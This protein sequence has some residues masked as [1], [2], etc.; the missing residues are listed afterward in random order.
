[1]VRPDQSPESLARLL[2]FHQSPEVTFGL[3]LAGVLA[4][5]V[6]LFDN[7]EN[8]LNRSTALLLLLSCVARRSR[9]LVLITVD[10][11]VNPGLRYLL[12]RSG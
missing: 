5:F 9:K 2:A 11:I 3:R 8:P 1:M 6:F 7:I 12:E 10:D 4:I